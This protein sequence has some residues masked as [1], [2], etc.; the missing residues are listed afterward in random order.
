[1]TDLLNAHDGDALG[2]WVSVAKLAEMKG[3]SRQS[4]SE[5]IDRL[6]REGRLQTR[7]EGRSR[8]VEV[9]TYDRI[10]GQVGD[11]SREIGAESKRGGDGQLNESG[12]LR[13]A[14]AARAQYEAK[15][16]ALDYA[17]RTGQ[18]VPVKGDHGIETALVKVGEK[19]LRD[20]GAPMTWVD[21]IMSAARLGEPELRR[22]LRKNITEMR[23]KIADNIM[24]IAGEAAAAENDGSVQIDLHFDGDE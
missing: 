2:H 22:V 24:Q 9:A 5:K 19:I 18:L 3:I 21:E 20:L 6:E 7:R 10:V 15:L 16:K 13:D 12:A 1:M 17:E 4:V 14:Q 23:R 8:M 11:A